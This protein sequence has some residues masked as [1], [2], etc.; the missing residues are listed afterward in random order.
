MRLVF[1]SIVMLMSIETAAHADTLASSPAHGGGTQKAAVCYI[2]N[3]SSSNLSV[4]DVK[5]IKEPNGEVLPVVTN[6]CPP[7]FGPGGICRS[8]S[9][10]SSGDVVACIVTLS[11]EANARASM[12]IRSSTNEI[13]NSKDLR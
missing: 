5:I 10:L 9:N 3:S 4:S 8:V 13:L 12:E 1:A 2:L 7:T 11:P 6:N